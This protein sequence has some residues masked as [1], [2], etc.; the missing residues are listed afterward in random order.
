MSGLFVC[1]RVCPSV[2]LSEQLLHCVYPVRPMHA[3]PLESF[4]LW[5][6]RSIYYCE[7]EEIVSVF[8]R[9]FF[10]VF[11]PVPVCRPDLY[12]GFISEG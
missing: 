1:L 12:F 9:D 3:I 11:V 4:F 7:E 8:V 6:Q 2:T 10:P 5:M